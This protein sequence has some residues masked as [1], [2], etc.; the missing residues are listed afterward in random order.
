MKRLSENLICIFLVPPFPP[1]FPPF[2]SL[3]LFLLLVSCYVIFPAER[4]GRKFFI[5]RGSD[6]KPTGI[7]ILNEMNAPSSKGT[8]R[9]PKRERRVREWRSSSGFEEPPHFVGRVLDAIRNEGGHYLREEVIAFL[10]FWGKCKI[11]AE[12]RENKPKP[13]WMGGGKYRETSVYW[14]FLALVR[15]NQNA[16][17]PGGRRGSRDQ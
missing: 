9:T 2:F 3:A 8:V 1:L 5:F 11:M 6:A 16:E 10:T 13:P 7:T 4:I 15:N 17:E 12:N 14:F